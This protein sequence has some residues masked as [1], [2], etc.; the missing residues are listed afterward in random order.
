MEPSHALAPH[1]ALEAMAFAA[2]A[3]TSRD[4]ERDLNGLSK[5]DVDTIGEEIALLRSVAAKSSVPE[6]ASTPLPRSG[7]LNGSPQSLQ[8]RALAIAKRAEDVMSLWQWIQLLFCCRWGGR[9]ARWLG[10][11]CGVYLCCSYCQSCCSRAKSQASS[12]AA[13][14]PSPT[15]GGKS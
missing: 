12:S 2:S 15:T 6:P 14:G 4:G 9:L 8:V 10:G 13:N 11:M 3:V 5:D 1:N 7:P